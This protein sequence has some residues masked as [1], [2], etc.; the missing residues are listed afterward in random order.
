MENNRD[1]FA[2]PEP[3]DVDDYIEMPIMRYT[4]SYKTHEV[5]GK[6]YNDK[7]ELVGTKR[8]AMALLESLLES[9]LKTLKE[10]Y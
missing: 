10:T 6:R 8:Q 2:K 7:I 1:I 5:G 9:L 3:D 4:I